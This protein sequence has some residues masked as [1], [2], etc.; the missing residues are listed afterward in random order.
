MHLL[1]SNERHPGKTMFAADFSMDAVQ[2]RERFRFAVRHFEAG[3]PHREAVDNVRQ[4]AQ[5]R[6]MFSRKLTVA[7]LPEV[8]VRVVRVVRVVTGGRLPA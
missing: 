8:V 1:R 2:P 7:H 6:K 5:H 4:P 3:H